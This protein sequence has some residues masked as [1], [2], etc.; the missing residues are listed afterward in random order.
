MNIL[1]TGAK[2][3][4]GKNLVA[5]LECI[6]DGKD[7]IHKI[8]GLSD[9]SKLVIYCY[10]IDSTK[11]QLDEYCKNADFVFNLAGVN[12]PKD[13]NEF[14]KGNFGFASSLLDTLKKYNNK[15]PVMLASSIQATL[16]GRYGQSEYGKSK[17]AGEEL[18]FKYSKDTGAKVLVYRFPNLF[19]KWCRPNYNSAV[20]TFCNNIANDIPIQVNDRATELELLYIDDLVEEMLLALNGEEHHC[21]FDGLE[22]IIDDNGKYCCVPVTHKATLGEIVDLLY[23]FKKQR[24]T[25]IMPEIPYNSFEKKLYS[26]YLTYLPK[27]KISFPLKMNIDNRGSFTELLKTDNCGQ[28]SVNISRPG[29]TKGEHW[30]HSK[31]EFFIVV[32][33]HGLIQE[34][35]ID[36]DEII[37]FEVSGDKIE[38]IHM[39]PGYTH[40]IIN[41]SDTQDLITVMW[42]NEQFDPSHP[43]TFGEKVV[44]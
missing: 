39:L 14:K 33:G 21:E 27:E 8:N 2:G 12:R 7:R 19:G 18:F 26:T 31:W 30:H 36:S 10:D 11:E 29:I 15:C 22:T 38:A 4:V 35:K 25:L 24:E 43:D 32:S 3:F 17:L 40:N 41:L 1:V 23:S 44:R 42:A 20:A 9:P 5:A 28:F 6:R 16:I 13:D 37:E 34:R